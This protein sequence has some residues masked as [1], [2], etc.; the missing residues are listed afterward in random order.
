M[1]NRL[2]KNAESTW[3]KYEI[4]FKKM[5]SIEF[6][7]KCMSHPMPVFW[8]WYGTHR[9]ADTK[10]TTNAVVDFEASSEWFV[11]TQIDML[12]ACGGQLQAGSINP[13]YWFFW[14]Y[15]SLAWVEFLDDSITTN[16]NRLISHTICSGD[17]ESAKIHGISYCKWSHYYQYVVQ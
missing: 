2:G 11:Q 8:C 12:S 9:N 4:D 14:L 3:E 6:E 15:R 13:V 5:H 10:H 17:R 1:Q 7:W 16:K